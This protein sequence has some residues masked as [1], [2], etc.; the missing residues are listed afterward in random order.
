M[1]VD[2]EVMKDFLRD[3][4]EIILRFKYLAKSLSKLAVSGIGNICWLGSIGNLHWLHLGQRKPQ[5]FILPSQS[6]GKLLVLD[7]SPAFPQWKKKKK[8]EVI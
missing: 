2:R 5:A 6:E 3:E 8:T 1:E 4:N 7:V